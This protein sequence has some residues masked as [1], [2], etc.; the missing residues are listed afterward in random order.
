MNHITTVKPGATTL[1]SGTGPAGE[2]VVL[3]YQRYGRGKVV[4]FPI[5]DSWMWQ[6]HASISLED[7]THEIFWGQLLRWLVDGVPDYVSG[8]LDADEAEPGEAV[9]VLAEINDSSF[10]EVNNAQVQ[11]IVT[12]PDG[13][14]Q[15]LPMD[16]T[17]ERDGEYAGSFSPRM[18]G[19]YEI[20]VEANR[21]EEGLLGVDDLYLWVGPSTEEYFDAGLRK[22][23][24][25][26]LAQETGGAYYNAS[27]AGRLPEDLQFTGAG[28]TLTE[29]RDLWDMPVLFF[30]LLGFVGGEWWYRR[31]RGLV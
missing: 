15:V 28:V 26:R 31:R 29:E 22:S 20:R 14:V 23:F 1:L 17:V 12:A 2:Q 6:L 25:E 7:Q 5:L 16:W 8:R 27:T 4:A 3:A 10:V 30:L 13:S 21:G 18:E 9:R 24:L 19:P 11:A